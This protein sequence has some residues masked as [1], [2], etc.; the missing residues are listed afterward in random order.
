M[1]SCIELMISDPVARIFTGPA[2][3][4]VVHGEASPPALSIM[5]AV[6]EGTR[7]PEMLEEVAKQAEEAVLLAV[8]LDGRGP[9]AV[10]AW[11]SV[12]SIYEL[13]VVRR[14][15]RS[16]VLTDSFRAACACL[17]V[18][19]RE[20]PK[21]AIADHLLF[22][23]VPGKHAYLTAVR[24]LGHG[25]RLTLDG[26]GGQVEFWRFDQLDIAA[27][28]G[29]SREAQLE[30]IER[31][32]AIAVAR[33]PGDLKTA[34]LLSGGVDSTLIQTFLPVAF[35]AVSAGIDSPEFGF[36]MEYARRA[37][38]LLKVNHEFLSVREADYADRL[39]HSIRAIGLPPHHLQTVLFDVAFQSPHAQFIIGQCAD[40]LFGLEKARDLSILAALQPLVCLLGRGVRGLQQARRIAQDLRGEAGKLD[41]PGMRFG[42]YSSVALVEQ[43]LGRE[44]VHDSLQGRL[45]YVRAIC[46]FVRPDDV[47]LTAHLELGHLIGIFCGDGTSLWRQ[48]AHAR[49]R[50]LY[51]PFSARSVFQTALA[52]PRPQR[53]VRHFRAKHL[54]KAL[55]AR[56]LSSYPVNT[57]KGASGLPVRRF[58][59]TGPL[60]GLL[61][62]YG[63][64]DF[65]PFELVEMVRS[66][67]GWLSWN[68]LTFAIW[69]DKVL[70]D[71]VTLPTGTRIVRISSSPDRFETTSQA[72]PCI[73]TE[74]ARGGQ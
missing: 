23:T 2:A 6:S 73:V 18:A 11:R 55:L 42:V 1:R 53:Y 61:A 21:R 5:Q 65:V 40:G 38:Q 54:L 39:E 59:S 69:R 30:S 14:S 50:S 70:R 17:P 52:V 71:T 74:V 29:G 51:V 34:N 10:R 68:C 32:L 9:R 24:R 3:V 20:V 15:E 57:K 26:L 27:D 43:M 66:G 4:V 37:G 8:T 35:P 47:G 41:G 72:G 19:D 45:D 67:S 64:P 44:A 28:A 58:F 12:T 49:E 62:D 7:P 63:V 56:R 36:E 46:P 25:E 13:F 60:Q 33:R 48:L 16:L 22:R 31:A